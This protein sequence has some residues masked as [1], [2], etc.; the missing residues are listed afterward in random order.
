MHGRSLN[1]LLAREDVAMTGHRRAGRRS[2]SSVIVLVAALL[3]LLAACG[4]GR[5]TSP[6]RSTSA[7]STS[8]GSQT[9]HASS[10]APTTKLTAVT[11]LL[12]LVIENHSLD[13]MRQGM[14]FTF[15]LAERYGY[16]TNYRALTH[17]S[18]PNYLAMTGGS[19]FGVR[20]DAPPASHVIHGQSVFGQALAAG[21]SAK[22][23]AEGMPTRCATDN[24]GD[25]YAVKHNPWAYFA[26]ERAE[27]QKFDVPLGELSADIDRGRLPNIGMIIPNLCNDAHDCGLRVADDWLRVQVEQIMHGPDWRSGHL[28][29]VI[30]ADEDDR[31]QANLVLT[32]VVHPSLRHVVFDT[33]LSHFSLT[34]LYDWVI[35]ATPLREA[36]H[37]PVVPATL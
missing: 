18:L 17:P 26:D 37:A 15:G 32:T 5:T 23:Y 2:T 7:T 14:P 19:T 28:A 12:V 27:C 35:G 13:Q 33:P 34:R 20:D 30:T 9:E 4:T 21:K 8:G 29:L 10:A 36:A 11:K 16:A 3:V 25:R 22:L 24:G 6:T 31:N 1:D